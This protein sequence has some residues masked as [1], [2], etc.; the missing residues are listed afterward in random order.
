MITIALGGRTIVMES[1]KPL[2]PPDP[3]S[4]NVAARITWDDIGESTVTPI[5]R[6]DDARNW[7][8]I[9]VD[10]RAQHLGVSLRTL[11]GRFRL[12]TPTWLI[13][14]PEGSRNADTLTVSLALR[15]GSATVAVQRHDGAARSTQFAYGA[16]HGWAM[17]N[18][19]ARAHGSS[20]T[21]QRWTLAWLFGW[22]VLL[23]LATMPARRPAVWLGAALVGLLVCTAAAGTLA[24]PMEVLALAL[25]AATARLT[26]SWFRPRSTAA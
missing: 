11:A 25:G 16:Q 24:T 15:G 26:G 7:S 18:P 23:G 20:T 17:I 13:A 3:T 6:L 21:W 5:V 1:P 22:G 19:F 9:A 12:R 8:I 4:T 14:V 2:Q 10:R